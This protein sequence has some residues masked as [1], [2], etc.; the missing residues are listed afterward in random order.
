MY[1]KQH[2]FWRSLWHTK[3]TKEKEWK[4]TKWEFSMEIMQKEKRNV[5]CYC[6][7][8]HRF[9]HVVF[10]HSLWIVYY[11]FLLHLHLEWLS[12]FAFS[13]C[14]IIVGSDSILIC[15]FLCVWKQANN[16]YAWDDEQSPKNARRVLSHD[17]ANFCLTLCATDF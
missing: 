7:Q 3:R 4:A 5:F 12:K 17:K 2:M 8:A 10:V 13:S 15:M 14:I 6:C 1:T 16:I 9:Q 11:F